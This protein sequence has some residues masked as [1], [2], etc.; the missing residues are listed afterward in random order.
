M[1][2][3]DPQRPSQY[4]RMM[5]TLLA[6]LLVVMLSPASPLAVDNPIVVENQQP[7]SGNWMWSKLADDQSLQIKGFASA[8][9]VS[10]N[11]IINFYVTVNPVQNYTIDFYRF[12]W[13]GGAGARLRQ[14]V[15]PIAGVQQPPCDTDATTGLTSCNWTPGHSLTVPSDWT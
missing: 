5:G 2:L 14:H 12:G 11:G 7:G 9:S 4:R 1:N 13:Y 3:A 6:F 15:G 10:Q 8:T